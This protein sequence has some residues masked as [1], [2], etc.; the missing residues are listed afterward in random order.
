MSMEREATNWAWRGR[1]LLWEGSAHEG[2]HAWGSG[3]P[4]VL[5]LAA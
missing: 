1:G 2:L 5:E 3:Q 4:Q